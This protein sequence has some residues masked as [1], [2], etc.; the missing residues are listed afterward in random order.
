MAQ[1][2]ITKETNAPV[3]M[4]RGKP[5][6]PWLVLLSLMF[7]LFMSL[8]DVTIV[9]IAIPN[10]QS[11]LNTDL[12]TVTWV[13]NAYSLVFAVLLVTIGRLADQ[14]GRKRLFM[15]GML[16]FSAGS[17]LCALA[18]EMAS[19]LGG[20]AIYWLIGFRALQAIGAASLN[21][22]SLA[23]IMAVFPPKQRG[24]AIGIWGALS[25]LAAAAG[26]VLGGF[27]VQN[28]D[29]RWIFF[30]NLP[31]CL[32]GI[33]MVALFV[34][35]THNPYGSKRIDIP[36][37][38][39]LSVGLFC[40]VLAIIEG[41]DWGWNSTSI[42]SLFAA[43]VVFLALFA[44]V[45]MRVKEPIVDFSLFKIGTFTSSSFAMF[46]FGI[47]IQGAFL[48]LVLYFI[49]A[50]GTDQLG[51]AYAIMPIPIASFIVSAFA[52]TFSA[53]IN[54]R[55]LGILGMALLMLGF[56]LLATL[57]ADS[58]Y[59]DTTW[60]GL[61]IGAGM[62]LCFQSFP[63]VA[64]SEVARHKLGVGSGVFNTFRQIGFV[65]GVAILISLFVGQVQNNVA[66][67]QANAIAIVQHDTAI[68]AQFRPF[69]I[70]GLQQASVNANSSQLQPQ[71]YDLTQ[72]ANNAPPQ[73]RAQARAALQDLGNKIAAEFKKAV[74][75]AFTTTWIASAII[76]VAGF[77]LAL[78]TFILR[79][80][81]PSVEQR[82]EVSDEASVAAAL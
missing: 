77:I 18:P 34:P 16:F 8:L 71:Q 63:N 69:I 58:N 38:L 50:Q 57:N 48:V 12:T 45:E 4:V 13:L 25:G 55:I 30:V 9:N 43:A 33:F 1:E 22:V 76:A 64:L 32:I 80:K 21:S 14:H 72:F 67:A 15:I 65:L 27:L 56:F 70:R 23:I 81:A 26:P 49:S 36:G 73:Y 44:L 28:F 6:N 10:M 78:L 11:K 82:R 53:R 79:R 61:L 74:V 2:T 3:Y 75:Q 52:G 40:L 24:A 19:L 46:L 51:A 35:E 31:F 66:Q 59:L 7:G 47:A 41:N 42:L 37:V 54:P 29:W 62:G 20:Q 68:P 17:L 39:T 60:R 5:A